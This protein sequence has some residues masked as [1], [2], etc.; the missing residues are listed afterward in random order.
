VLGGE[1][2]EHAWARAL[3]QL[4]YASLPMPSFGASDCRCPA[5]LIY[6]P[7]HP[8]WETMF[9]QLSRPNFPHQQ[10]QRWL[11]EEILLA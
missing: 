3:I 9:E 6:I 5:H 1:N 2:H 7:F 4:P 11:P 10:P 8:P